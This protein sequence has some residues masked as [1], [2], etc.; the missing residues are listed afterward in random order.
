M[1]TAVDCFVIAITPVEDGAVPA[2]VADAEG[3][4]LYIVTS[5][6]EIDIVHE[7]Q[8][9]ELIQACLPKGYSDEIHFVSIGCAGLFASIMEF[10]GHPARR[11]RVLA[12]ETPAS[13]VQHTLDVSKLGPGG[14]GFVAQDVACVMDLSKLP[15]EALARI[16]HCEILARRRTLGGTAELSRQLVRR[17]QEL[18][19]RMPG[20]EIVTFENTS[21][22]AQRLLQ[23]V[24]M[25]LVPGGALS[26]ARWLASIECDQRHFMSARP[27][28]DMLAHL[29]GERR[30]PLVVTCLGAGGRVGVLALEPVGTPAA[31]APVFGQCDRLHLGVHALVDF[32]DAHLPARPQSMRYTDQQFYG[33]DNFYFHWTLRH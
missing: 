7:P 17:L 8:A 3:I 4:D 19:G 26:G 10:A 5:S 12:L 11:C 2:S 24:R 14:D 29:H 16:G 32:V 6:A 13:Y 15:G 23:L 22:W 28:L 31:A 30:Q 21:I 27:L 25:M 1:D 20:A 33:R 9:R 18:C